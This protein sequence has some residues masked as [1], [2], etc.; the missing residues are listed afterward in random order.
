MSTAWILWEFLP[1]DDGGDVAQVVGVFP[2]RESV[3]AIM[4]PNEV[5]VPFPLGQRLPDGTMPFVPGEIQMAPDGEVFDRS[6]PQ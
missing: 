2:S 3:V 6:P 1:K 4:R 5:A